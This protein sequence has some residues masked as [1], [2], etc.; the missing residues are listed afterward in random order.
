MQPSGEGLTEDFIMPVDSL[1]LA[2]G[3]RP[4]YVSF[5]RDDPAEYQLGSFSCLLKFVSKEVD[6]SSGMPEET[7]YD[8]EYQLEEVELGAG[9]DYIVP[10]YCSFES[11][12]ERLG[13][14]S[15]AE[16]EF[17]LSSMASI[18]GMLPGRL[19]S[20]AEISCLFFFFQPL[21]PLSSRS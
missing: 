12:W 15:S 19:A 18:K 17:S 6:P 1:D 3:S 7:G 20:G 13:E 21:V 16:E 9:G 4:V 2:T 5:T 10:S 14:D 8:D 11:E